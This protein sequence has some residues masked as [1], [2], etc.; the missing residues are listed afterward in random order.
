MTSAYGA[1]VQS[2]K[3]A[4]IQS[5]KGARDG[6]VATL[7]IPV[8]YAVVAGSIRFYDSVTSDWIM[9]SARAPL[10]NGLDFAL[11]NGVFQRFYTAFSTG[12]LSFHN[13]VTTI[14]T[15][16]VMEYDDPAG[17]WV[18]EI[19]GYTPIT[20]YKGNALFVGAGTV[21]HFVCEYTNHMNSF[22]RDPLSFTTDAGTDLVTVVGH[23]FSNNDPVFITSGETMTPLTLRTPYLVAN[24]SGDDFNLKESTD[25]NPIINLTASGTGVI[26]KLNTCSVLGYIEA[27]FALFPTTVKVINDNIYIISDDSETFTIPSTSVNHDIDVG[28][29]VL[30]DTTW[31]GNNN[32][33]IITER[34]GDVDGTVAT[35]I[36]ANGNDIY[37]I[38]A[39]M[40]FPA[41]G[42]NTDAIDGVGK[43]EDS[44][45]NWVEYAAKPGGVTQGSGKCVWWN[46]KLYYDYGTDGLFSGS[47]GTVEAAVVGGVIN[48]FIID[49]VNNT[50]I[51][52]GSYSSIDAISGTVHTFDG[53]TFTK[54]GT[55]AI[56][57]V[58]NLHLVAEQ[59]DLPEVSITT[60][61]AIYLSTDTVTLTATATD[62]FSTDISANIVWN[63]DIDGEIGTG[64]SVITSSLTEGAHAITA[65]VEDSKMLVGSDAFALHVGIGITSISPAEG[66]I[67]GGTSVT[68]T[69]YGYEGTATVSF[70]GTTATSIVATSATTITCVTPAH[71]AAF[72]DVVVGNGTD[73]D[74]LTSGYEYFEDVGPPPPGP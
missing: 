67:A 44:I 22:D 11:I 63:S 14:N 28:G 52:G 59:N 4:Y 19:A 68:I 47:A 33:A 35:D 2:A 57:T 53:T 34:W 24:V 41:L 3:G 17:H 21:N 36:T 64:A 42:T 31:H 55:T 13:G 25:G 74:T 48:D 10:G 54:I 16:M 49:A 70:D 15:P 26:N 69:G 23:T 40:Y 50:L 12:H 61:D 65:T 58:L 9:L 27:T 29:I 43:W 7:T 66:D 46:D 56:G 51:F 38:N 45:S 37:F 5:P 39:I 20:D 18:I 30:Y 62:S 8:L 1:L 73:T 71:A 60:T 72:V 32:S 6:S